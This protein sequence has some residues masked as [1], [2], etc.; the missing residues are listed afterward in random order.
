MINKTTHTNNNNNNNNSNNS[1]NDNN[2]NN[3]IKSNNKNN[4]NFNG[5]KHFFFGTCD[6]EIVNESIQK[7]L[8][9]IPKT[10]SKNYEYSILTLLIKKK[11]NN[12]FN[13]HNI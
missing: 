7:A 12:P 8:T 6:L 13:K 3:N 10:I 1:N 9:P 11:N 2:N 5:T 4:I